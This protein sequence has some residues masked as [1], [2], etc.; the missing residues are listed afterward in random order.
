MSFRRIFYVIA[1]TFLLL[2]G[3]SS[4]GKNSSDKAEIYDLGDSF[5]WTFATPEETPVEVLSRPAVFSKFNVHNGRNISRVAGS[6]GSYVWLRSSF[7]IP[8]SLKE[9]SLGLVIPHIH[10][11]AELYINGSYGGSM[12]TFPPNE[13]SQMSS[14]GFFTFPQNVLNENGQNMILIKV[15]SEG[16]S[17]ISEHAY[18]AEMNTAKLLSEQYS[19]QNSRIYLNFS[20]G[21]FFAT[22]L[23]FMMFIQRKKSREY[24]YFSL[25]NL[26]TMIF[27]QPFF[28]WEM[29]WFFSTHLSFLTYIKFFAC[30]PACV[31]CYF[32][33]SFIYSYNK[34]NEPRTLFFVRI[35][36]LVATLA[37]CVLAPNYDF[38]M[39]FCPYALFM[40]AIQV[41]FGFG[42]SVFQIA[43]NI[44][45][46]Q[47]VL[48]LCGFA[49]LF[50]GLVL[51]IVL[52]DVFWLFDQ[53]Y[54]LVFGWQGTIV[55]FLIA[56]SIK[57]SNLAIRNENLNSNL[58]REV[59]IQTQ[60][61]SVAMEKLE[62]EKNRADMD[63][64]MAAI[65]QQKFFPYPNKK[66]RGWDIATSYSPV[67]KVSGDLYDYYSG[68]DDDDDDGI[69]LKGF[70]L[71][72]VSGHGISSGLITML[73]KN[74]I[75]R[76]FRRSLEKQIPMNQV[77]YQINDQ[78]IDAKGDIENYLTGLM[79]RIGNFDE[80]DE[81]KIEFANAG[82]PSPILFSSKSKIVASLDQDPSQFHYGAIGIKDIAISFPEMEFTMGNDDI[83]VCYTDGLTEAMNSNREEFGI[84]R[85]MQIVRENYARDAQ[86]IL[87]AIIDGLYDFIGGAPREDDMTIMILKRED[88]RNFI[89]EL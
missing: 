1:I 78:I 28:A 37:A 7:I 60:H 33:S 25:I 82:H 18:L 58:S 87:E 19:S 84:E 44:S 23:F 20:G 32:I 86:S 9:K 27:I 73:S 10:F 56:L 36:F 40:L 81:C 8:D 67:S 14:A 77:L 71:F 80:N 85:V 48:L 62:T 39:S 74:I 51:D 17:S 13:R 34:F 47:N 30:V 5:Y 3:F 59:K 26:A 79:F 11:A 72:D 70:S 65:V 63:M 66:F 53:P 83:I 4:C 31:I 41:F 88:S 6:N 57:F 69:D 2:L 61:L 38:L 12:G 45:R 16:R 89:E 24:L 43:K 22:L 64:E 50:I 29:P 76:A 35:C 46:S 54:Y 52:K 49:P 15:W 42:V 21:V 75:F 68:D 55:I